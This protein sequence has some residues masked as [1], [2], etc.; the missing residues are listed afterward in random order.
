MF[1]KLFTKYARAIS[2]QQEGA[3]LYDIFVKKNIA[4]ILTAVFWIAFL[5]EALIMGDP[6]NYNDIQ[7][8]VTALTLLAAGIAIVFFGIYWAKFKTRFSKVLNA[9]DDGQSL[10]MQSYRSKMAEDKKNTKR[11]LIVPFVI[12]VVAIIF[13]VVAIAID[14]IK[15]PNGDETP[16][17]TTIAS[18][19]CGITVGIFIICTFVYSVKKS[20]DA[21]TLEMQTS[22]EVEKI[23]AEQGRVHK[24]SIKE[25]KNIQ[26][27]KYL[28]PDEKLCEQATRTQKKQIKALLWSVCVATVLALGTLFGVGF[29]DLLP[30]GYAFL[31]AFTEIAVVIVG[32][33]IPFLVKLSKFEKEQKRQLYEN[34][35]YAKNLEIYK[36]Y[37]K[38]SKY[39][40]KVVFLAFV[41]CYAVQI[42]LAVLFPNETY[43]CASILIIFVG[44]F[45]NNAFLASL[46]K[47]VVPLENEIDQAKEQNKELC[48]QVQKSEL[49]DGESSEEK[50]N[51][52]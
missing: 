36:L 33:T 26:S 3:E 34:P 39:R 31:I 43:C 50:S 37:E 11:A 18:V 28:F 23:D 35:A 42:L 17:L 16:L 30:I 19:I 25:D 29:T 51:E 22:D 2:D 7:M 40:G 52:Q 10:Q 1:K 27:F 45:I 5:I 24:Y 41:V 46:R 44:S 12:M 20:S 47:K 21:K 48:E 38:H 32:T 6:L 13:L 9:K 8:V 15:N 4:L 14:V 49:I